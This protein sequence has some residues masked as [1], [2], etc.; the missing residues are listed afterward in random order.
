MSYIKGYKVDFDKLRARFDTD[1]DDPNN[2]RFLPIVEI[3]LETH[4][5]ILQLD[6][7]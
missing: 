6:E 7:I 3:F 1:E 5:C 4:T 2:T